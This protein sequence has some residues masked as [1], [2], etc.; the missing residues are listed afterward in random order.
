VRP[1]DYGGM[2]G[3]SALD[4]TTPKLTATYLP[5]I[6]ALEAAGYEERINLW[7]APYDWRLAADGLHQRGVADDMQSLIEL[8][9]VTGGHS[10]VVIVAH[11]MVRWQGFKLLSTISSSC[12]PFCLHLRSFY[13]GNGAMSLVTNWA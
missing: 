5:L 13:V 2:Q 8:A 6:Q 9:F 3:I 4:P 1:H 10:P 12:L 11:S 7:G